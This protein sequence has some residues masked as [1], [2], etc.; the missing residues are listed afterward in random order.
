MNIAQ[1]MGMFQQGGGGGGEGGEV[2]I[3]IFRRPPSQGSLAFGHGQPIQGR[4]SAGANQLRSLTLPPT[5]PPAAPSPPTAGSQTDSSAGSEPASSPK[6]APPVPH[7]Q[8]GAL[9]NEDGLP[10]P[11]QVASANTPNAE[12]P[13][14]Q[15]S[16]GVA[17]IAEKVE[18]ARNTASGIRAEAM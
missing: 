2:P 7:Q 9:A 18:V 11:P 15:L 14:R 13:P 4:G 17:S 5:P 8:Q 16:K 10:P 6:A 12:T 3:T 1:Q